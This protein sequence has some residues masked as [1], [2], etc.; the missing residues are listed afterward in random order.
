MAQQ[1]ANNEN[2]ENN[3][4]VED[5]LTQEIVKGNIEQ[6]KKEIGQFKKTLQTIDDSE[7]NYK[8]QW[9]IDEK[10]WELHLKDDNCKQIENTIKL[11]E[12]PEFW[13]L[14][15][16]KLEY[17]YR[18]DKFTAENYL[19][20]YEQQRKEVNAQLESSLSKLKELEE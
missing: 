12:E 8:E 9:E 14:H 19:K 4:S 5:Q 2:V 13:E 11:H 15:K 18:M 6:L 7:K 16:K 17:K 3:P 20:G 10:I 1:E